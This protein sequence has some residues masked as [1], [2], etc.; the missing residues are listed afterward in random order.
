MG[1]DFGGLQYEHSSVT[2]RRQ[3][4][5]RSTSHRVDLSA[6]EVG[7]GPVP[8]SAL[9]GRDIVCPEHFWLDLRSVDLITDLS[10]SNKATRQLTTSVS[11]NSQ[12]GFA[13]V[14]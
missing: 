3:E 2:E 12:E 4:S 1:H 9:F 7:R 14:T 6:G 10:E 5:G 13:Q 11:G 8:Q